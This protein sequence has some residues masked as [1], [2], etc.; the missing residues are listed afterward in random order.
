MSGRGLG[1]AR[2]RCQPTARWLRRTKAVLDLE[3]TLAAHALYVV[4]E[5]VLAPV[6]AASRAGR[7]VWSGGP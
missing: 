5:P 2:G 6:V 1:V 3:G 4:V 7:G